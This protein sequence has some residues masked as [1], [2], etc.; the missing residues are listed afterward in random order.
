MANGG[1]LEDIIGGG[2][3]A[4]GIS[5]QIGGVMAAGDRF[6]DES[7][8]IA[9]DAQAATQFRP[10][11]VVSSTG[12]VR[13]GAD[14]SINASLDPALQGIF[15][16][17]VRGA[18]SM[19]DRAAVDPSARSGEIF[20]TLMASLQPGMDRDRLSLAAQEQARGRSGIS[21]NMFG[22][23]PEQLALA[24]AQ[25][26]AR[27]SAAVQ[28]M[29]LAGQEQAREAQIGTTLLG[30]A[31]TPEQTLFN[32][33]NPAIQTANIA[34]T[35]RQAGADLGTQARIAGLEG[36]I[37]SELIASELLGDLYQVAGSTAGSVASGVGG[38]FDSGNGSSFTDRL[39]NVLF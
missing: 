11:S 4:A 37:N 24:K 32:Q 5:S 28:A 21:S 16:S 7:N 2:I 13:A 33:L 14:G 27:L 29:G 22:G 3:N 17:G 34:Q 15:G 1:L 18:R 6:I 30:A 35:G 36:D 26:E 25:E 38:L 9:D 23:T 19:F 10:F 12:N 8:V 31:L 39:F 20:D